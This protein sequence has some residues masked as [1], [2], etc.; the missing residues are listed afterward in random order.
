M[1]QNA[2]LSVAAQ[3]IAALMQLGQADPAVDPKGVAKLADLAFAALSQAA[4]YTAA[5]QG[6]LEFGRWPT[7]RSRSCGTW[8][9]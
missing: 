7:I 5:G 2:P 8:P 1:A 9:E 6:G 3:R 4:D